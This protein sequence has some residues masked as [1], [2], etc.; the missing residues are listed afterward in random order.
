M[1]K[2]IAIVNLWDG[3][4]F[5]PFLIPNLQKQVDEIVVVWSRMSNF[6]NVIQ[7]ELT[8]YERVTYVN[9][10]PLKWQRP[11]QNEA[12]KR[13]HG[14]KAALE[15]G[16]THVLMCDVDEFY[17]TEAFNTEKDRIYSSGLNGFVCGLQCYFGSPTLTIGSEPTRVPFIVKADGRT[18]FGHF[19]DFPFAYER[20]GVPRIDPT[21]R[22][23]ITKGIEW[24]DITMHHYSWVRKDIKL[25]IENS[26]ARENIKRSSVL[27]DYQNANPGYLCRY[28]GKVLKEAPNLFGIKL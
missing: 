10:E 23:N 18:R 28:Y 27:E 9:C 25:K 14:L 6:G 12:Q 24:S 16:A 19:K 1:N 20:N 8:P 21:R 2:L 17:E 3:G 26:S 7:N 5:L 22:L 15:M 4:E 11:H 13:N